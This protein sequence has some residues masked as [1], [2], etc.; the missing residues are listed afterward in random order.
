MVK[1]RALE[2]A[3]D[4]DPAGRPGRCADTA[5]REQDSRS[6]DRCRHP[7]R[8]ADGQRPGERQAREK[9]RLVPAA[10]RARARPRDPRPAAQPAR[11]RPLD[12]QDQ[13]RPGQGAASWTSSCLQNSE[14]WLV[15]ETLG[16]LRR[17]FS[18][19]DVVVALDLRRDRAR[20]V[21]RRHADGARA[22]RRPQ[23][24]ARRRRRAADRAVRAQ[25]RRLSDGERP[26]A[27]GNALLR[28]SARL[29]EKTSSSSAKKQASWA[30]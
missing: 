30:W 24:H 27:P 23:L 15:R 17:T 1:A 19:L 6:R 25:L 5:R 14:D 28:R 21:L 12:P 13:G 3:K 26:F 22:R 29:S 10:P 11:D 9:R 8:D 2:L 20:L 16:Y 4:S 7:H 18:R